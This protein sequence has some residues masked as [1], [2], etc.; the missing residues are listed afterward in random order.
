VKRHLAAV[1]LGVAC[2]G[3]GAAVQRFYDSRRPAVPRAP[4]AT[5]PLPASTAAPIKFDNEPLWAYGFDT[6]PRPGDKAAPQ[7]PPNR[8]LRS[9][10]DPAEQTRPRH[11]DGSRATYSLVDVR[12]G[13]NVIDWFPSDHPPMPTVVE[14]GPAALGNTTRGCGSCHLPN[15]KGRPENAPPA[16]LPV[17]YF[18]R[19]IQDFRNGLRHTADPRKPNTNTMI[20]LAKAMTDDEVTAAAQ[21]F[22]AIRWSPWIRVVETDMVPKTR[23]SG[24]LFLPTERAKSEPIAGRIIEVP[25]NEAQAETLRNPHSG[26]VAY[27]PVGSIEKGR[28]LVTTGGMK[29]V[30]N[31]IVAGKT[32]PCLTCHG[33]D[34][35]GVA[36]VPP[37]AGRSPSYIVRQ[38]WD[39][40]QGTRNGA[41][42][43]LMKMAIAK[44]TED[45]LVAIAAYVSSRVPPRAPAHEK[46]VATLL[47]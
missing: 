38:I 33:L 28:D 10:E 42:A 34:L 14:H 37:I 13:Q 6:R 9:N 12:D 31:T 17:S 47:P 26:F 16:G 11:V 29:V 24:N 32:T 27:V 23:I 7:A 43:Q 30:G 22:S 8:N 15:G 44:L 21:Y 25:E 45:D 18:M 19:Q 1:V 4:E 2:F 41:A 39:M 36:D 20:D 3:L 5:K 40:Q 46:R 35:M